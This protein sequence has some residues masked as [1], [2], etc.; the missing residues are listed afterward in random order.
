MRRGDFRRKW[1]R[2]I[3]G[4][5][6]RTRWSAETTKGLMSIDLGIPTLPPPTLAARR[7]TRQIRVGKVLVVRQRAVN[8]ES[9]TDDEER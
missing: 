8:D 2:L 4:E 7:E 5:T 6:A 1:L 3:G 9:A